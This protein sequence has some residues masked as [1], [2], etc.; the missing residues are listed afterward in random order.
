MNK[1]NIGG[2]YRCCIQQLVENDKDGIS[3]IICEY[4]SSKLIKCN[5]I[6]SVILDEKEGNDEIQSISSQMLGTLS[7][8][9]VRKF[10]NKITRYNTY[11]KF[12]F[13]VDGK[14]Y[15]LTSIKF[16]SGIFYLSNSLMK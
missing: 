10:L 14:E 15:E 13:D 2:M 8:N 12:V 6:W 11:R 5:D 9:E 3:E 7:I 1:I 16:E 4:C